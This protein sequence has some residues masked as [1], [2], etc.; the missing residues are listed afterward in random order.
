MAIVVATGLCIATA[1]L[2]KSII[3]GMIGFLT[4]LISGILV[5]GAS[6]W[7]ADRWYNLGFARNLISVFPQI[8]VFVG[9]PSIGNE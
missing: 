9:L 1:V 7:I 5:A 8:A 6:L 2:T 4:A 3:P